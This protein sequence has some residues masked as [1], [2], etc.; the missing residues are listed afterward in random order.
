MVRPIGLELITLQASARERGYSDAFKAARLAVMRP[1]A[2]CYACGAPATECD[3]LVPLAEG[4]RNEVSNL[5]PICARCHKLN[6]DTE[7]ERG[8]T[9]ARAR[10]NA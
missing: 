2:T 5:R 8:K 1:G 10:R 9:R 6:T 4:G 7:R 3:H